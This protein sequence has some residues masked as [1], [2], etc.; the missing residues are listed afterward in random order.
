[1][2]LLFIAFYSL[3]PTLPQ[4]IK[5]IGRTEAQVGLVT[6]AFMLSAV[7]FCPI[8]G[9][10]SDRFGRRPFIVWGLLIFTL[11]MYLYDWASGIVVL[12]GLRILHGMSWAFSTT[13]IITAI[14]EI[15]PAA[16]R[17]EG[18]GWFSMAMTLAMAIGPMY[19]LWVAQN[20][21][22]HALFL[23]AVG[24]S[25]VSLLLT[26]GAQTP[27]RLRSDAGRIEL[28]EKSVLPV[29]VSVFFLYIAL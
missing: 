19:G 24:L 7:I 21:S 17:G 10:L 12:V 15:I 3:L 29:T 2:L 27:F 1:M 4:F 9:A 8:I 25:A 5:Q 6:G 20:L 23:F 13:A 28:F 22:Y 16:R 14:T 18:M 11:A 26:F